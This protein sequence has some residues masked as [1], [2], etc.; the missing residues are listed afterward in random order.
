MP[1]NPRQQRFVELYLSGLTAE[2]SYRRAGYTASPSAARRNA[3]RLLTNADVRAAI[4]RAAERQELTVD[5]V[6]GRL[7][8]EAVDRGEGGSASARV[9]ALELLGKRL[10]LFPTQHEISG[11]AGGPVPV[12]L[13]GLSDDQLAALDGLL[14][15]GQAGADPGGGPGGD[16]PAAAG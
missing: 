9:R 10:R 16:R 7:K 1:L 5:W 14:A 2:E 15:L 11:P 13:A 12:T 8:A 6:L 3:S 4:D